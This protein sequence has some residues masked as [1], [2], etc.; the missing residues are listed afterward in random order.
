M[1]AYRSTKAV[2]NLGAIRR[3]TERLIATYPGYRYYTAVVKADCYGYRGFEV[4]D[5]MLRGGCNT[6]AASLLEEGL[7]LREVYDLPILL[8]TPAG[9]EELQIMAKNN[10]IATVADQNQAELAA[11]IPGLKV[12]IR[13]NGGSDIFGGPTDKAGFHALWNTLQAGQCELFGIY[14]HSYNAE[15]EADTLAEY[16][17]FEAITAGLD[18]ASLPMVSISNSLTLPRYGKKTYA[19]G[20]RL[21]NIIYR[22]ESEDETL[23]HTF[24][25]ST[26]VLNTF[27]LKA[28][29]SVAYSHAYTTKEDCCIASVPIGFGDGFSKTN[30]GRDVFIGTKRYPIVA[31]TMD[32]SHILVDDSVKSGDEVLLIRDNHHLDEVA[33]HIHGATEEAICALNKRVYREYI[34]D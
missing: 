18:L 26:K 14:L 24:Q 27:T 11:K 12:M 8:F 21:G 30:I 5:A 20:C 34:W 10:L 28:G 4:V 9:E 7:A 25:L 23:E 29:R 33:A 13:A 1:D 3:N 15:E 16:A 2:I 31:I 19:N 17:T 22:I 32:I 6:L